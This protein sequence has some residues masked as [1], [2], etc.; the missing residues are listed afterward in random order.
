MSIQNA[1]TCIYARK[2]DSSKQKQQVSI[3]TE[4]Y[5]L[6]LNYSFL[7]IYGPYSPSHSAVLK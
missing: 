7:V 1:T 3:T 2:N 4:V 5:L 6:K